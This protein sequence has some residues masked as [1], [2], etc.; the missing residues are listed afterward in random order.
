MRGSPLAPTPSLSPLGCATHAVAFALPT[1]PWPALWATDRGGR[2]GRAA[3]LWY[4]PPCRPK[5]RQGHTYSYRRTCAPPPRA[6]ADLL[7]RGRCGLRA[8]TSGDVARLGD[9]SG[10]RD[11]DASQTHPKS[12]VCCR[13]KASPELTPFRCALLLQQPSQPP[14]QTCS[15]AFRTLASARATASRRVG[16][17]NTPW[18]ER[19]GDTLGGQPRAGCGSRQDGA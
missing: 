10:A 7:E 5:V 14:P 8:Q 16:S 19:Q 4:S 6:H 9:R 1:A 18:L 12:I 17:G 11:A 3:M 13:T 2:I 15:K